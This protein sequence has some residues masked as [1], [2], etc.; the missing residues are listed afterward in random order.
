MHKFLTLGRY[1][2]WK[3]GLLFVKQNSKKHEGKKHDNS[4][5]FEKTIAKLKAESLLCITAK[6]HKAGS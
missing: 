2:I 4:Q 6:R 5:I 1:C 3:K